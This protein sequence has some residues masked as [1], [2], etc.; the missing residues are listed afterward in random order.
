LKSPP[1]E[2]RSLAKR[3]IHGLHPWVAFGIM[4]AFAFANA[5]VSLAG[6]SWD[7]IAAPVTLGVALGL[8][9]G[10]QAGVM[11]AILLARAT[12]IS[13]LPDGAD[14]RQT[15]G[16]AILTGI[17]FTMSLFIGGLAFPG[18]AHIVEMRLG[19]IG[20]SIL[21]ATCGLLVLVMATRRRIAR[22]TAQ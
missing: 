21:S 3:C 10:K 17:G 5:G 11:A 19:V 12:G 13:R 7:S 14:W 1:G 9:L 2:D 4:P 6:L 8:F 22:S 20:G 18:S 16:V 15:Y